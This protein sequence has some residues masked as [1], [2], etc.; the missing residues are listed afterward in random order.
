[1]Q[2]CTERSDT[3]VH[4]IRGIIEFAQD[5]HAA[6]AIYH[7]VCSI[8]LR[9]GK[10]LPSTFQATP[11]EKK[12]CIGRP[13]DT[14]KECAFIK[15]TKYLED[16]D[17]EQIT[18]GDLVNKMKDKCE[19]D[20]DIYTEKHMKRKLADHFGSRIVIASIN[21][22]TDVVTFRNTASTIILREFYDTP[23]HSDWE[24]EKRRIEL[25]KLLPISSRMTLNVGRYQKIHIHSLM[26][27]RLWTNTAHFCQKPFAYF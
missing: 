19:Q 12:R 17:D 6:D 20:I 26:T 5:V 13:I 18:I 15:V 25:F 1:M 9:T 23:K 16:N 2:V 7:Q 8:N 22:K 14:A 3:W 24:E 11:G 10:Q 4:T 21:V 27:Y